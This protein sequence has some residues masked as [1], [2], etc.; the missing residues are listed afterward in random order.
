MKDGLKILLNT[1]WGKEGW[2]DVSI[3]EKNFEIAKIEGYMFEY[4]KQISHKETLQ[5]LNNIVRKISPEDV[6]NA[7]L[8]SLTTRKL[9]Y[10]SALGSYWYAIS[11]PKHEKY[12]KF[13]NM[14]NKHCDFCGWTE[15]NSKPN[16]YELKHGLNVYNFERYKFGG[17]RHDKL[18]YALF[19]LEQFLKLPKVI[20]TEN[21]KKILK[22]ILDCT[23]KLDVNKK[24]GKLRD[25]IIKEKIFKTNK[26]E[27]S[28]ILNI[29]GICGILSSE[30]CPCYEELFVGEFARGSIE[31]KNDFAYPVNRWY[32]KDGINNE[33]FRK[34]FAYDI[35][36]E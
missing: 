35:N 31:A 9:E 12:I 13:Q 33:R 26:D 21:D 8:Y 18:N 32:I 11:I 36:N 10:R 34:V 7:F 2:K 16:D 5:R 28:I 30:S 20:P 6:A 29:L 4:P 22:K 24:V 27:V 25:T 23:K 3:S 15:W 14:G 1:Y 17:V 19:D